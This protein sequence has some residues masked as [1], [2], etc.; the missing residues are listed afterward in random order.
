MASA[1]DLDRGSTF[2]Y[3]GET[4]KVV[5]KELVAVGTHSHTKMKFF[6]KPLFGGGEKIIT[7]AH[8]DKVEIVEARKKVASVIAK[9][10]DRVQIMDSHTYEMLDAEC[11]PMLLEQITEGDN[12][13]F[14]DYKGK[15][16][17]VEKSNKEHSTNEQ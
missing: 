6:V 5:R 1:S 8:N 7:L 15:V 3:K 4:L 12:I 13:I 11:E 10:Q 9:L 17:V 16:V 2:E 14:V